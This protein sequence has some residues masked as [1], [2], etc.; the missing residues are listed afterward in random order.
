MIDRR[1][2]LKRKEPEFKKTESKASNKKKHGKN[3]DDCI[4]L[5]HESIKLG[6]QFICTCCKQTWFKQSVSHVNETKID[7]KFLTETKSVD[8]K[9]WICVTCK[10]SI[11][12][13]KIPKLAVING[14]SFP[15]KPEEL[16]LHSLEECLISLRIPL[17]QIRELPRGR[18]YSVKGNVV[19]VPVGI[20]PVVSALPR[21]LDEN[22]TIPIKLKKKL[23]YKSWAFVENVRPLRVLLAL[24]WL[25]SHRV[26]YQN[27][28]VN[29]YG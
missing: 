29:C 6:P 9:Q 12:N 8:G 19:N 1:K 23:S 28:S 5:F 20:Q 17:I 11:L 13:D 25:K 22:V 10:S 3:I 4:Q 27:S 18:Q 2:I 14:M 16:D 24:H 7:P 15:E 26:L 21:P